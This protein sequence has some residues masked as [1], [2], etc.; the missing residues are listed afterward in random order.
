MNTTRRLTRSQTLRRAGFAKHLG[1][2]ETLEQRWV[3]ANA[4]LAGTAFIDSNTNGQL[5]INEPYL[6]DA[7]IELRSADGS[8]L[9]A[10]KTTNDNGA[11]RFDNLEPGL[12]AG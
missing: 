11:Y 8:Q 12:Q 9:I 6:K 7:V 5:D 1:K 10:T 3:M 4:F 2:F